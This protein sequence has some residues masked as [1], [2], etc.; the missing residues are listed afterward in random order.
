M[1]GVGAGV[2]ARRLGGD[3]RAVGFRSGG[4]PLSRINRCRPNATGGGSRRGRCSERTETSD[5]AVEPGVANEAIAKHLG[6]KIG[7]PV[8]VAWRVTSSEHDEVLEYV[9]AIYRGDGFALTIR[10]H[11][12][13]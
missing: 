4:Q 1:P 3:R 6:I 9:R 5:A 7:A 10:R 8:V 13:S 11:K 2:P 12:I